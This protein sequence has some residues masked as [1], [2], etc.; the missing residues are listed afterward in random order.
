[1][2]SKVFISYRRDDS[3]GSA[4]RLHDRLALEFGRDLLFMDVDAIPLGL[5]FVK[6]LHEEVAKCN[7]L[8]AVI[9]PNWLSARDDQGNRRLD[10]PHDFV[11]VEI[12]AAL[13]RDIPVIPILLDGAKVPR[14]EQLPNELKELTLRNGL[15]VRHASFHGDMDKLI[16]GL[17]SPLGRL[18]AE[19][20]RPIVDDAPSGKDESSERAAAERKRLEDAKRAEEEARARAAEAQGR[21][22]AEAERKRLEDAR[23]AEEEA[24]ARAAEAQARDRA[25]A[26]RKR[27]ED[28]KRT[29]EEARARAAEAQTRDRADAVEQLLRLRQHPNA[30]RDP[31]NAESVVSGETAARHSRST[32]KYAAALVVLFGIVAALLWQ[33]L[34]T[35]VT[36]PGQ[37]LQPAQTSTA[38]A[39]STPVTQAPATPPKL[40]D[41]VAQDQAPTPGTQAVPA[42][43]Q[44]AILYEA[45]VNNPKNQGTRY[46][47]SVIWHTETVSPGPGLALELTVRG[48]IEIPQRQMTVTWTLRRNTDKALPASHTIEIMFNLPADFPGGGV[49][50]VPGVT[51]KQAEQTRGTPLAGLAVKVTNGFFLIGLSADDADKRRNVQLLKDQEWFDIPIVYSNGNRAILAVEKGPSGDRAFADGF[52]AW[53]K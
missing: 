32:I 42:V 2:T 35:T 27:L 3:A 34:P 1:M 48:D 39:S 45:D 43:A 28:A 8:L 49:A 26:E 50:N 51:M 4:G 20:Q 12:A 36:R 46:A 52:A 11:R 29:E 53:A 18:G 10:D 5:N 33:W 13:Q 21:D 31:S 38:P 25:E 7:V 23:R 40:D 47:G 17:K 24:R 6:V 44:R 41:R 16:R 15:D 19:A 14:P 9:G 22:R 37:P 30:A